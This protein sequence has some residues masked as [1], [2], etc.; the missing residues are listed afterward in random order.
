MQAIEGADAQSRA[1]TTRQLRAKF[2]GR[3]GDGDFN[4]G[5]LLAVLEE[6]PMHTVSFVSSN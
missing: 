6:L 2:E 5:A 1:V 4:P 3:I